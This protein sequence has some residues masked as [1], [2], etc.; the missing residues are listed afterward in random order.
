VS[1]SASGWSWVTARVSMTLIGLEPRT[2]DTV[3]MDAE[4][5]DRR[6]LQQ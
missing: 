4:F 2:G 5:I 6:L 1:P 3:V